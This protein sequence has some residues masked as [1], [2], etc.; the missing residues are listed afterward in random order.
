M[1]Y[2]YIQSV[3]AH[4]IL[5]F[6]RAHEFDF[7]AAIYVVD[8][9]RDYGEIRFRALGYLDQRLHAL[10]FVEI[11]GGIRIISFRKAN[12]REVVLYESQT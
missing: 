4:R 1:I 6:E 10:V 11:S 8:N 2:L 5:S 7:E 3:H 12:R 9:R